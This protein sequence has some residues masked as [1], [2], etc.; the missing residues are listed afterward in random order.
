MGKCIIEVPTDIMMKMRWSP[1]LLANELW[2][3]VR[4]RRWTI[5]IDSHLANCSIQNAFSAPVNAIFHQLPSSGKI[6]KLRFVNNHKWK[7]GNI[8]FP[9][10]QVFS[11]CLPWLLFYRHMKPRRHFWLALY[12][13]ENVVKFQILP[14]EHYSISPQS[15]ALSN[16]Y[17]ISCKRDGSCDFLVMKPSFA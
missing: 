8:L 13:K 4:N 2:Y 16:T 1:L 3:C 17:C 12:L 11:P 10:I 14:P 5:T 15:T 6:Y 7:L 9:L